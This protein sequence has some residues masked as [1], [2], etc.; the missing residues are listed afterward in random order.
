MWLGQCSKPSPESV[1]GLSKG[2]NSALGER[3]SQR[4]K[5]R[6]TPLVETC[7]TGFLSELERLSVFVG[8][9]PAVEWGVFM[10]LEAWTILIH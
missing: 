2:V 4:Q 5:E 7:Q 1:E 3:C 6:P 8:C 10:S 9:R